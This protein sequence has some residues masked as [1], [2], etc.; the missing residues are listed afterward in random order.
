M[1]AATPR[2][3][4][5]HL[6]RRDWLLLAAALAVALL[7]YGWV[8]FGNRTMTGFSDAIDYLF[9]ADFYRATFAGVPDP[10]AVEHYRTTRFPP[11]FPL[12][13]AAFGGGSAHTHPAEFV[14]GATV[15][16]A[17]VVIWLWARRETHDPWLALLV[18]L[19]TCLNPA[20]FLLALTPASEPLAMAAT[21]T[22]FLLAASQPHSRSRLLA[23]AAVIGVSTLVRS[24]NIALTAAFLVWLA[25]RRVPLRSSLLPGLVSTVPFLA[26]AVYRGTLPGAQTY[27]G[28]FA[29][30]DYVQQ[31]GG[32]PDLLWLQPWHLFEAWA[33]SWNP[34][35]R[36]LHYVPAALLLV[37]LLPGL[38][39]RLR[40]QRL[41]AWFFLA[42]V[43]MILVWPYPSDARRFTLFVLPLM[44]LYAIQGAVRV[45]QRWAP[46]LRPAAAGGVVALL[47]F[48]AAGSTLAHFVRL[49]AIPVDPELEG[50]KREEA[51]FAAPDAAAAAR[52]LERNARARLT[53]AEAGAIA[54]PAECVYATMPQLL[55]LH[56]RVRSVRYPDD[57]AD[58][59]A[60][61]AQL[62]ACRYYFVADLNFHGSRQPPFYPMEQLRGWTSIVL[63]SRMRVGEANRLV[64]ALF[65]RTPP[66]ERATPQ[67]P[68]ADPGGG[69]DATPAAARSR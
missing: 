33:Q 52:S 30:T 12:L 31:L 14:T 48:F 45:M 17:V 64:A 5:L 15:V 44:V 50:D 53:A 4:A 58:A 57:I 65:E 6:Q 46:R 49:A 16:L 32:W 1:I 20:L 7:V 35:A 27:L 67:P 11:L 40:A 23:L 38:A 21:W 36:Q 63:Q 41:D 56:G 8:A 66:T 9:M 54:G 55:R 51:Y 25:M 18:A 13:L 47:L 28:V 37:F 34:L 68:P 10:L 19:A 29:A 60:A 61:Q 69:H 2:V 26:W 24:A 42:Y 59:A 3:D 39:E 22:A 62:S 43:G